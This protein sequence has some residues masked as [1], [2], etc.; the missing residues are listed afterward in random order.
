M[1]TKILNGKNKFPGFIKQNFA[2]LEANS[3]ASVDKYCRARASSHSLLN[4]K[5][6]SK[7]KFPGF[8]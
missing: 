4:K 7:S 3:Q 6:Q 8:S 1:L 5:L 2:E